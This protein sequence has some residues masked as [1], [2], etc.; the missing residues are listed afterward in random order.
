MRQSKS[1]ALVADC[2]ELFSHSLANLLEHRV[3][4]AKVVTTT[5]FAEALR[6]LMNSAAISLAVFD[7][8][9]PDMDGFSSIA[10]LRVSHPELRIA[11]S[12]RSH[13]RE[14]ILHALSV[15]AHGYIPRSLTI[16]ETIRALSNITS[17]QIYVPPTVSDLIEEKL[18]DQAVN[19]P[20]AAPVSPFTVDQLTARQYEV[21]ML[22][23]EGESNKG[24]AL[25]LELSEG[26]VKTHV[27]ALFRTLN[28]HDRIAVAAIAAS[29]SK[30][31]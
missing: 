18:F 15:G 4:F 27:H 30:R 6:H 23:A 2:Q 24:I 17:G 10:D 3:G 22:I 16:F 20:A 7:L 19:A 21:M 31:R 5:H 11:V 29:L 26:T 1:T 13:H 14:D 12:G 28:V 25:K 8:K 9:L